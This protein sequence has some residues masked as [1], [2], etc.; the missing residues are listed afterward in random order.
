MAASSQ[1]RFK[2]WLAPAT[3]PRSEGQLLKNRR[4]CVRNPKGR[5]TYTQTAVQMKKLI[6]QRE[7]SALA[8]KAEPGGGTS[9]SNQHKLR[10]STHRFRW[11]IRQSKYMKHASLNVAGKTK[12]IVFDLLHV[13]PTGRQCLSSSHTNLADVWAYKS[14][15]SKQQLVGSLTI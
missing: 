8:E 6:G 14:I 3:L 10:S 12:V 7:E 2:G 5:P 1:G 4:L 9:T 15:P 11:Q 13:L